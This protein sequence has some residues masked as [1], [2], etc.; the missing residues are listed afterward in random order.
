[1]DWKRSRL[2]SK[3]G[4]V[5]QFAGLVNTGLTAVGRPSRRKKPRLAAILRGLEGEVA[6][7]F[8]KRGRTAAD[9][10]EKW[11]PRLNS[12]SKDGRHSDGPIIFAAG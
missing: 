3:P 9:L 12:F 11:S 2:A 7:N 10:I 5:S 8:G 6:A 1:V 4:A